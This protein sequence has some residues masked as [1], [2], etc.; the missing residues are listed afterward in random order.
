MLSPTDTPTTPTRKSAFNELW[1]K[2]AIEALSEE[3][4]EL[5]ASDDVPWII[6]YSGGKDSTATLQLVWQAGNES[7]INV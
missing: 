7:V 2:G 1:L 5:Y 4:R 6:G 3:I